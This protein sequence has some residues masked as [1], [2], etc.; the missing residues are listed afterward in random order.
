MKDLNRFDPQALTN[1]IWV[2]ANAGKAHPKYC[3][4]GDLGQFKSQELSNLIRVF[5]TAGESHSQIYKK[6][7]DHIVTLKDLGQFKPQA[8]SNIIWAFATVTII[9]Q[10]LFTSFAPAVNQS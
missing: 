8:L 3:T 10:H 2:H 7:A 1:I 5:E 6:L 9:D 4:I